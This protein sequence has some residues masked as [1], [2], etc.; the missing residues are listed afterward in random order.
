M[1]SKLLQRGPPQENSIL[2]GYRKALGILL[3]LLPLSVCA[4][5]QIG[6]GGSSGVSGPGNHFYVSANCT[7]VNTINCFQ[8]HAD[9][10]MV[11]DA[12]V[13]SG[14]PTLTSATMNFQCPGAIYPCSAGGD[15]GKH[16]WAIN[17]TT[18]AGARMMTGTIIS[19]Q[20]AT[21]ATLNANANNTQGSANAVVCT[22]DTAQLQAAWAAMLANNAVLYFDSGNSTQFQALGGGLSNGIGYMCFSSLPFGVTN[23]QNFSFNQDYVLHGQAGSA[24]AFMMMDTYSF[25]ANALFYAVNNLAGFGG[26]ANMPKGGLRDIYIEGAGYNFGG[27]GGGQYL[28]A[29][30]QYIDNVNIRGFGGVNNQVAFGMINNGVEVSTFRLNLQPLN[31]SVA[32][33]RT[34]SGS[35]KQFNDYASVTGNQGTGTVVDATGCLNC[36]FYGDLIYSAGNSNANPMVLVASTATAHFSGG[37]YFAQGGNPSIGFQVDGTST[38]SIKDAAVSAQANG[39]TAVKVLA[40]GIATLDTIDFTQS[41]AGG[42]ANVNFNNAGTL[43]MK[44]VKCGAVP[45]STNS[46]VIVDLGGNSTCLTPA[47]LTTNTGSIIADGHQLVGSCTGVGTAASTLGLY[48]TGANVVA[49]T[50]TSLLIGTGIVANGARTI[51]NLS[52][53]ATA[54][55]TNASSGVVTVLKNGAGTAVTCTIGVAT[56]CQDSLHTATLAN[57]DRISIQ[58]TTQAADTLAGVV[59]SVEWF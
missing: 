27:S 40:G 46:G 13:T 48:G 15:V 7:L 30:P 45:V 19:I 24:T 59:A 14:Q 16:A 17:E 2:T 42:G 38:L 47:S 50:C 12:S 20:S 23:A 35:N 18:S 4:Q 26:T 22:D 57:G 10:R 21:Q 36:N 56:S 53:T 8:V 29:F 3:F 34:S 41:T 32:V 58:F 11:A 39:T 1:E 6:G 52:V 9:G 44:N 5:T 33:F 54:A 31:T 25:A 28:V 51:A 49:T 37:D 55:G 43:Y